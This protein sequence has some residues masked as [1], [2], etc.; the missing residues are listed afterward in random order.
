MYCILDAAVFHI[1]GWWWSAGDPCLFIV[2]GAWLGEMSFYLWGY[3]WALVY[4]IL[5][6]HLWVFVFFMCSR[7]H[8]ELLLFEDLANDGVGW[9][10]N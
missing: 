8:E 5:S 4:L 3:D 9:Q 6:A 1:R 7:L 2:Y 10:L